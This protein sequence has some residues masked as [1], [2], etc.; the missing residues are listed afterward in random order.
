MWRGLCLLLVPRLSAHIAYDRGFHRLLLM[1]ALEWSLYDYASCLLW[2]ADHLG[3][4]SIAGL[5]ALRCEFRILVLAAR[6]SQDHVFAFIVVFADNRRLLLWHIHL[7]WWCGAECIVCYFSRE[8]AKKWLGRHSV[9][10][11]REL[12]CYCHVVECYCAIRTVCK[13]QR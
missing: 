8:I 10:I 1:F 2:S 7:V 6:R 12:L 9:T 11:C 4:V 13:I 5:C 3:M